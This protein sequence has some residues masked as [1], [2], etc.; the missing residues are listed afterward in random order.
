[1]NDNYEMI[2]CTALNVLNFNK[3][4]FIASRA[5][6]KVNEEWGINTDFLRR[7][8][9]R[10]TSGCLQAHSLTPAVKDCIDM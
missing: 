1:M 6:D 2:A 7:G 9:A 8:K 5:F 3:I 10:F 4:K